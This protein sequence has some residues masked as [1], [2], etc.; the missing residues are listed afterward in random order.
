MMTIEKL[1]RH[2]DGFEDLYDEAREFMA[3]LGNYRYAMIARE[4]FI[5]R[6]T[7]AALAERHHLAV[8]TIQKMTHRAIE[9]LEELEL[10][11]E[12]K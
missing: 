10:K 9:K 3:K 4:Y 2:R 11:G 7:S 12:T 8:I 6:R 1:Y 5:E